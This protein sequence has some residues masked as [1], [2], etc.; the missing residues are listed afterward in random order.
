MTESQKLLAEYAANGSEAA[1]RELVTRYVNFVYSTARRLVGA[2]AH[3]AEDVTQ[4]VFINLAQKGRTLSSGV[5][6]GGWLHQHTYHV[7]TKAVRNERRRQCREREALEMNALHEDSDASLRKIEPILDEAI[8]QLG[9]KDRTAILLRFF[10][11]RDFQSV[12]AAL[13]SN[14]DAARM[15]VKRALEKLHNLLKRRGVSLPIAT[16]AAVLTTGAVTAAPAGLALAACK[17]ALTR[18]AAGSGGTFTMIKLI[19]MLK[20]KPVLTALLI[21]TVGTTLVIYRQLPGAPQGANKAERPEDTR[22]GAEGENSSIRL[23]PTQAPRFSLA[24]RRA[25][26]P[27][28][29]APTETAGSNNIPASI[30]AK[31]TK[32][33]A[34]QVEPYLNAN[35]RNATSLLAAFRSTDDPVFLE[36]AMRN[37]PKDP[38]VAFEALF[39]KGAPLADRGPWLEALKQSAP[40]NALPNYLSALDQFKAGQ[41]DQAVQELV[42]ASAKPLFQDYSLDRMQDDEEAYRM[43]GRSAGDAKIAADANLCLPYLPQL[44][45]LSQKI[46]DLAGSYQQA[47]DEVSRQAAL[48]MA[49]SLGRRYSDGSPGESLISQL[50]GISIER[51][52]LNAMDPA[53]PYG[54]NHQTVQ[55]RLAQ[56]VQQRTEIRELNKQAEP[57]W[58]NM[59]EEDWAGYLDRSRVSGGLRALNWLVS[60]Y[61][62]Q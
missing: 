41:A 21:T 26:A 19:H 5:L 37:Y 48:Q 54:A 51:M 7:A 24:P 3:L 43:A 53:S 60:K 57:L 52:A 61:A 30:A 4:T 46:V 8:T 45:E 32:L 20:L 44:R 35:G 1:F 39:R 18:A 40:E 56:L 27:T 49:A 9:S 12:G 55:D 17:L 13:G 34:A 2:E 15:R 31:L 16:L 6:L 58:D 25:T 22:A 23:A 50:V 11:R 47:G 62:Q 14:E 28:Q 10:E 42:S 36:E 29:A 59:S 38:L 33:T